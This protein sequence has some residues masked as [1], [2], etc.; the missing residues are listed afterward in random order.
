MR[1]WIISSANCFD[2]DIASKV[3]SEN[4]MTPC[5]IT[6]VWIF[7]SNFRDV[8]NTELETEIFIRLN[9]QIRAIN[10]TTSRSGRLGYWIFNNSLRHVIVVAQGHSCY[11][12]VGGSLFCEVISG[13]TMR[14]FWIANCERFCCYNLWDNLSLKSMAAFF[15]GHRG[16][17]I[18]GW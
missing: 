9:L 3:L 16:S 5:S 8:I 15:V 12:S 14:W 10:T 18:V 13:R 17:F 7:R 2:I 11:K 1:F 6:I 4:T